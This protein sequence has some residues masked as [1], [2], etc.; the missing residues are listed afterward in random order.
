MQDFDSCQ[1]TFTW[2]TYTSVAFYIGLHGGGGGGL[3]RRKHGEG[4]TKISRF[5]GLPKCSTAHTSPARARRSYMVK[6]MFYLSIYITRKKLSR[7]PT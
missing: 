1:L 6:V 7:F 3:D 2:M 4:M 5:Q